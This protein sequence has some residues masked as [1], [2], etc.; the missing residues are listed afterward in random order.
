MRIWGGW[1]C[2]CVREMKGDEKR[3]ELE[4]EK[5]GGEVERRKKERRSGGKRKR[6]LSRRYR[7]YVD[8]SS[9]DVIVKKLEMDKVRIR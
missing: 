9:K 7:K 4:C 3:E 5:E 6:K 8:V 1:W 2:L